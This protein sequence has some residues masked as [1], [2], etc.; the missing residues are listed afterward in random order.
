MPPPAAEREPPF[1]LQAFPSATPPAL[2]RNITAAAASAKLVLLGYRDGGVA[3]FD[4]LGHLV[5]HHPARHGAPVTAV[6]LGGGP[7]ADAVAASAAADATLR[8]TDLAAAASPALLSASPGLRARAAAPIPALPVDPD[9]GRARAGERVAHVDAAGRVV[10]FQSGWFGGTETLVAAADGA[11]G[12]GRAALPSPHGRAVSMRWAG[13]LL[14]WTT[15]RGVRVYDTRLGHMVCSAESPIP[16]LCAADPA[17]AA[18]PAAAPHDPSGASDGPAGLATDADGAVAA[19]TAGSGAAV[20]D[21]TEWDLRT[22]LL[23]DVDEDGPPSARGERAQTLYVAWP[24]VAKVIVIG[25][26]TDPAPDANEPA[27]GPEAP[28]RTAVARSVDTVLTVPRTA[29]PVDAGA[30]AAAALASPLLGVVPFG[31]HV[32]VLVGTVDRGVLLARVPRRGS[33]AAL[34]RGGD[35][36][37]GTA[38]VAGSDAVC[39]R[40]PHGGIK[41]AGLY[42][43]PGGEPLVLVVAERLA[44][45]AAEDGGGDG[46]E[47]GASADDGAASAGDTELVSSPRRDSTGQEDDSAAPDGSCV[48]VARPLGVAERIQ[49]MLEHGQFAEALTTAEE[50]PRGSLR[51]ADVS[52]ADVGDQ[53]LESIRAEGDFGRLAKVLP[54][55]IVSTSPTVAVRGSDRGMQSRRDRW[56]RWIDAFRSAGKLDLVAPSVPCFEPRMSGE[57]YNG[58]LIDLADANP[59]AMLAVLKTW[60]ADVYD[61]DLVT[62]AAEVQAAVLNDA[63]TSAEDAAAARAPVRE[64]LFMLYGL[65][66]RHD[67]TLNLLLRERSDEVFSFIKAHDLYGAIQSDGAVRDMYAVDKHRATELLV[68]A[69]GTLLPLE[70]AVPILQS[71]GNREWLCLYLYAAFR[72]DPERAAGSHDLL[73]ELL[74]EHGPDGALYSFLR[75]SSHFS[76]DAAL[77]LMGGRSGGGRGAFGRERVFVLATMGD[78]NAAMDVLLVELRDVRGAIEFAS[79]HGDAALWDRLIEHARGDAGTLAALLDSPAGG[80]VNPVRLIPLIA[81]DMEIPHLR[82]RLHRIL[83]D[84]ALERALR[85]EA[86]AALHFEAERLMRELD[87]AVAQPTAP[88]AGAP[89]AP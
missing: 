84:A 23:F 44:R 11:G 77:R 36:G 79:E 9:Y 35:A 76:L 73:L 59:A 82:D 69:P 52:I 46:A 67:E 45:A 89:S 41:S 70:S 48:L 15:P 64:A 47:M 3:L 56:A 86:A 32:A 87:D 21:P 78:L 38:T 88:P 49:W 51:R 83:V 27:A 2:L 22:S 72:H 58:I 54:R 16:A 62:Q 33:G 18:R 5:D 24:S 50:A 60:P 42:S 40:L 68:H 61:V 7:A 1:S 85:E 63:R 19:P 66:G 80:K 43:I 14:A 37:P 25:P 28:R 29:L 30:G 65:S 10:L 20:E 39:M 34:V 13:F 55:V 6:A 75:T 12:T 17:P 26:H 53:F 4:V 57:L 8:A 31:E 71:V 74:V 81:S